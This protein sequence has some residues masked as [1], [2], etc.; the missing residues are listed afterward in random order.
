MRVKFSFGNNTISVTVA[1]EL[2]LQQINKTNIGNRDDQLITP[3]PEETDE[4][5]VVAH[6]TLREEHK[7]RIQNLYIAHIT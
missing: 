3:D 4:G 1:Y 2:T 7:F 6:H 5:K